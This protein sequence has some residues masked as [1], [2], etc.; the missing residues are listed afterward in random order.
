[1]SLRAASVLPRMTRLAPLASR[2]RALNPVRL[3]V[4]QK[5]VAQPARFL[6]L[7]EY[8]SKGLM[9]KYGVRVQDGD[10]ASSPEEAYEVAKKLVAKNAEELVIKAQIHAGGRGKG[11]FNTGYKG[12]VKVLVGNK[13]AEEVREIAQ[14]FLGNRLIT[15]QTGP[16]GQPVQK[17]LVHEGITFDRETYFAILMD[18]A[19]QGPVIVASKEGGVEIEETAHKNPD[20]ILTQPVDIF[21]GLTDAKAERVAKALG[22]D[23][24][25]E[26]L[27]DAVDQIKRLYSMFIKLDATQVEI[28]P[29]V[30]TK[31]GKI[32]CVDAKFNFD[33]NAAFRQESLFAMRDFSME[34]PRE[35]AASKYNLNYIGLD[36][37]IGCMVNGAGLAMSTMDI[38]KLHGGEPANF[39]DVGGGANEK[40]VE[41]A[42]K[43]LTSDPKVKALLV[44]IFGGIMQCD[45]IARGI[46][47]AAKNVKLN[48]PLVVRLEGTNVD[49][50]NQLLKESGISI[51]TASDLDEAAKKA[52][53]AIKA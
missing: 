33:D 17:V 13:R 53:A 27:A 12:G 19:A 29:F 9:A 8:Q 3:R 20:A 22:F 47:N 31:D 39:L 6:N 32:Y 16:E 50:G 43:I 40:Q 1:M 37:N 15:A 2:S 10:V 18:R 14:K 51:I 25:K 23:T 44:N 46:I 48:I 45:I 35:V 4:E 34:D 30:I 41:E 26:Q 5:M 52:V 11:T 21:E 49:K 38:I 42:F 28:N 36:G 7:H 24:S